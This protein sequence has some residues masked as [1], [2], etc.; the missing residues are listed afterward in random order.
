[1][2][3]SRPSQRPA[4]PSKSRAPPTSSR[5]TMS[6][7]AIPGIGI[8]IFSKLPATVAMP[9]LILPQPRHDGLLPFETS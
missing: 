3:K 9:L 1:M 4:M 8:P 5:L 6:G 2:V 7:P